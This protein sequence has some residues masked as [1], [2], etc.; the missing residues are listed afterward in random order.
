MC[1]SVSIMTYYGYFCQHG[2]RLAYLTLILLLGSI[3]WMVSIFPQW[4][5]YEFR[6]QRTIFY[7]SL[8]SVL[9]APTIHYLSNHGIPSQ[10]D[11]WGI[12]GYPAMLVL[13]LIGAM[14]YVTHFPER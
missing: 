1:G 6:I 14:I 13:Y 11:V 2:W 5:F 4:H 9:A 10:L 3:G 7:L 12:Y 8:A